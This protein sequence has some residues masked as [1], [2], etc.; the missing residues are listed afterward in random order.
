MP[1]VR[2]DGAVE[3]K[4]ALDCSLLASRQKKKQAIPG[5]AD[6]TCASG[7]IRRSLSLETSGNEPVWRYY[8]Q[9]RGLRRVSKTVVG[10]KGW[11]RTQRFELWDKDKEDKDEKG[12]SRHNR[13][14]RAWYTPRAESAQPCWTFCLF[15]CRPREIGMKQWPNCGYGTEAGEQ[16]GGGRGTVPETAK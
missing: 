13:S 4:E 3:T 1:E 5:R 10:G 6:E 14:K 9:G 2:K 8:L 16:S 12:V 11:P 15:L 7:L